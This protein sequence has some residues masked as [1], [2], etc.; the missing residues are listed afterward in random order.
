MTATASRKF[1]NAFCVDLEEWFHVCAAD[2]PYQ[3]PATWDQAPVLV[4][5]DTDVLLGLLAET[6]AKATFLTLGWVAE[7]HPGLIRRISDQGHEI[8]CHGYYHRLVF[9][10]TPQAF[11]DEVARARALLQD[12]SGQG[13]VC[14]RAPGFSMTKECFWAYEILKEL[15]FETDVSI[16]PAER[17]HGGVAGFSPDLFVL[18]TSRGPLTVFPVSVMRIAGKAI[19]FSGG[20]YLRLFPMSLVRWGFGQNHRQGRPVMAYTHPREIDPGQPRMDLPVLKRWKYYT[21]LDGCEEKLRSLLRSYRWSTV[22]DVLK[23]HPPRA[24]RVLRNGEI[25]PL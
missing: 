6:G 17:D 1:L 2:T 24:S 5:K 23:A 20:G 3:D 21:G 12:V 13:V 11:R 9:E 8:G 16:V 18:D 4:E 7:K 19:Q 14:F 15:G 25:L 10:Q 22:S